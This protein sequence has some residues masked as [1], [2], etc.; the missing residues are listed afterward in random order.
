[1]APPEDMQALVVW[2]PHINVL[3]KLPRISIKNTKCVR[4]VV[5]STTKAFVIVLV[6]VPQEL[7]N[8]VEV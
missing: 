1:M 4:L 2:N 3:R 8:I 5:D 6:G 7:S